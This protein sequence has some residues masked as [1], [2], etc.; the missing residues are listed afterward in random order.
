MHET[1][2]FFA[3]VY[4]DVFQL[5]RKHVINYKTSK[6]FSDDGKTIVWQDVY[7]NIKVDMLLIV[8]IN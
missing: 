2:F 5:P 4:T 8:Q 6:L 3:T 1:N 7:V